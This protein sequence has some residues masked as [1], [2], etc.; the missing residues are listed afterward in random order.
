MRLED[1]STE[2]QPNLSE[3]LRNYILQSCHSTVI[4]L[5]DLSRYYTMELSEGKS[6][7]WDRALRYYDLACSINPNLGVAHNQLAVIALAEGNHLQATYRLYRALS[8]R[9]PYPTA[10]GN[11]EIE[12]RKVLSAWEKGELA[13]PEDPNAQLVASFIYLHAQCYKGV[14]FPEHDELENEVLRQ[15]TVDIK[16]HSLGIDL[17]QKFC[18]INISADA[19]SQL[20]FKNK[21]S[22]EQR[23]YNAPLYF[24]QLNVKTFFT[25]LQVL[26]AELECSAEKVTAVA[27]QILPVLRNYSTWL[28]SSSELLV[29]ETK[30]NGLNVQIKEFWK[31]YANTLTLLT[32]T[33]DVA[34]L[35]VVDYLLQEDEDSLGFSPLI[36]ENV[37]RRYLNDND[38][39]KPRSSDSRLPANAEM[40]FR[41]RDFVVDGLELVVHKVGLA[42]HSYSL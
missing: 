15:I 34:D 12:F 2:P 24:R 36:S 14:E 39:L 32:S 25:L 26:L 30:D 22:K 19:N 35:P 5:G 7:K 3:R 33:F 21:S 38:Q 9:D 28:V 42:P 18:L 1:Y 6:R 31:I 4:R 29:K 16:E 37:M 10:N 8:A 40:L 11:L 20:R 17:L 27:Q 41:I 23:A 13:S